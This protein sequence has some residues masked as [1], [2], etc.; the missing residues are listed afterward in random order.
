VTK[1]TLQ[2]I[3]FRIIRFSHRWYVLSKSHSKVHVSIYPQVI[4]S[5][6]K[7]ERTLLRK[8]WMEERQVF[9]SVE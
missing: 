9:P 4:I 3:D 6:V 8:Y 7:T 1:H 2:I 5:R